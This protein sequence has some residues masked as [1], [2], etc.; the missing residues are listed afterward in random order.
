MKPRASTSN[1]VDEVVAKIERDLSA[2]KPEPSMKRRSSAELREE[3]T[4]LASR[5]ELTI[6]VAKN[7][8]S[9]K[10]AREALSM[11]QELSVPASANV[12]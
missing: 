10:Y 1:G 8:A 2:T 5:N 4:S 6:P 11:V 7:N 3:S 9:I 12:D